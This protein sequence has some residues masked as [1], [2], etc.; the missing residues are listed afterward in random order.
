[1]G[2]IANIHK[3][4]L[5]RHQYSKTNITFRKMPPKSVIRINKN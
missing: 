2:N 5:N 4:F 1:M 3:D